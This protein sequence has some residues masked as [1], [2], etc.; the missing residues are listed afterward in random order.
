MN[1]AVEPGSQGGPGPAPEWAGE[2]PLIFELG[3]DLARGPREVEAGVPPRPLAELL[4]G[5]GLR[6]D[7]PVAW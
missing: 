4:P 6:I 1:G 3:G 7:P 2:E 5:V